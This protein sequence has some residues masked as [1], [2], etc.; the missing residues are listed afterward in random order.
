[1]QHQRQAQHCQ[2]GARCSQEAPPPS[3]SPE[4]DSSGAR[5]GEKPRWREKEPAERWGLEPRDS[6][7]T[8]LSSISGSPFTANRRFISS[9]TV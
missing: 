1:M 3:P 6:D 2:P 9:V 7:P 4:L 5:V 8:T